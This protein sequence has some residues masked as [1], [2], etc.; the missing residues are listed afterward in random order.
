MA[1]VEANHSGGF[2]YHNHHAH[3][4]N[5]LQADDEFSLVHMMDTEP[6]GPGNG[7]TNL[8]ARS[9]A[10]SAGGGRGDGNEIVDITAPQKMMSAMSGK[11]PLKEPR[12]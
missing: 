7:S 11:C 2:D 4:Q 9:S 5:P 12:C 8:I 10:T 6:N 1:P 3:H